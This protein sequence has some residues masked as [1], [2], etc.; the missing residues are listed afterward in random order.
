MKYVKHYMN[1]VDDRFSYYPNSLNI[2]KSLEKDN[3]Y[4]RYYPVKDMAGKNKEL[5]QAYKE[6]KNECFPSL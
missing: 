5:Y 2:L 1:K 3:N 4:E 6:I